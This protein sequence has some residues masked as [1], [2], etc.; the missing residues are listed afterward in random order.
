MTDRAEGPSRQARV[1]VSILTVILGG[2]ASA[3]LA[4]FGAFGG[5]WGGGSGGAR[6]LLEESIAVAFGSMIGA[7][8][9][10]AV[11]RA[12][13][14]EAE[15]LSAVAVGCGTTLG[16]LLSLQLLRL[17]GRI[18]LSLDGPV[19][20]ILLLCFGFAGASLGAKWARPAG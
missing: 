16:L 14:K 1:L 3:T 12:L 2:L 11:L 6:R 9:A 13:D 8:L 18:G 4:A 20:L 17:L 7:F 15:E 5:G 10:V 19:A